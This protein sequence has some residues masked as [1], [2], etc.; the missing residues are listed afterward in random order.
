MNLKNF[1]IDKFLHSSFFNIPIT[2]I[3]P[4][5][6]EFTKRLEHIAQK[7][8]TGS[9]GFKQR[10]E[11]ILKASPNVTQIIRIM[12]SASYIRPLLELWNENIKYVG[13]SSPSAVP[14][15]QN[16][17]EHIDDLATNSR[18]GRLSR[19][20]LYDL[21][22]IFFKYY[23]LLYSLPSISICLRRHIKKYGD[24]ERL[25]GLEGLRPLAKEFLNENGHKFLAEQASRNGLA[26][27]DEAKTHSIPTDK[28]RFFE[29]SQHYH[30]MKKLNALMP[31]E[32]SPILLEVS[33][34]RVY[35]S[36]IDSSSRLGHKVVEILMGSLINGN[37]SPSGQWRNTILKIAGDPRIPRTSMTYATWWGHIDAKRPQM[38][39]PQRMREWL[40]KWD[41]DLFLRIVR[42]YAKQP[43]NFD[44]QR[45]YPAREK[46]MR[47]IFHKGLIRESRLFLGSATAR[48]IKNSVDN[49]YTPHFTRINGQ[50]HLA[51]FYF[52]LGRVHIIDGTHNFALRIFDR[53]PSNS[54]I[55]DFENNISDW[56][57]RAGLM[58]KYMREFGDQNGYRNITHSGL[59][60][61]PAVRFMRSLGLDILEK[62][63]M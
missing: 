2:N 40:S 62:D 22:R 23:N 50:N 28:S 47:G 49:D 21:C 7:A 42:E 46:F 52:N 16:I 54:P 29:V 63:V 24:S 30:Y 60:Q 48:Y 32:D 1:D 44:M 55:L 59:W 17:I 3:S 10:K 26:L 61:I 6:C 56:E 41:L 35:E 58:M 13:N 45:M 19:M 53:L 20:A 9:N 8:G 4:I 31:N 39:Y 43:C 51:V 38:H 14:C 11:A 18:K 5:Y 34:P 15:T 36:K 37:F 33:E 57:L 25:F 27:V 12:T